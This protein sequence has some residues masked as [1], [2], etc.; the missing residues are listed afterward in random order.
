MEATLNGARIHYEREG[1]GLPVIFLHAGVADARM[2]EPQVE[3]FA[4]HF[5]VIRVDRRGFGQSDLPPGRWSPVADLLALMDHL[6]LKPAHLVGC[7][8]GS[9]LAIDFVVQHPG[10]VSKL[11]SVG[12]GVG[13]ARF[14]ARYPDLFQ[15]VL[16]AEESNDDD[17]INNA[18][19]HLWLDGPRRAHGYVKE[20]LR[21]FFLEMNGSNFGRDWDSAP[22]EDLDPPAVERLHEITAPTLVIVGD[23]DVPSVFDAVELLMEKVSHARKAVIHDAAHLPSLEHPHEFNR[24]VQEFLLEG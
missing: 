20:P 14:H 10:R 2:W 13:G 6:D 16:V 8:L 24:I 7:S 12:P 5:D 18:E 23:E 4:K 17:A 9:M 11:V 15:E 21:S 1:E 3:A 22:T 19:M